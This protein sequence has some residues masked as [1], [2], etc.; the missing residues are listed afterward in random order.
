MQHPDPGPQGLRFAA[1]RWR[2]LVALGDHPLVILER[3]RLWDD[4]GYK[5]LFQIYY[6]TPT[7]YPQ[8]KHLGAVKILQRGAEI[9]EF[10]AEERDGL[11]ERFCSLG[12]DLDY[13]ENVLA[14]GDDTTRAILRG[15]RDM[16]NDPAIFEQFQAEEGVQRSLLRSSAARIALRDGGRLL[17]GQQPPAQIEPLDFEFTCTLPAFSEPHRTRFAFFPQDGQ[18]GRIV[19]LVGRNAAG[20]SALLRALA[21]RLSGLDLETGAVTPELTLL[22]RLIV[23]AY[24]AFDPYT[25]YRRYRS[26]D[27]VAYRYC[28]LRNQDG[29]LD[30]DGAFERMRRRLGTLS[31]GQNRDLLRDVVIRSGILDIEPQLREPFERGDFA[32]FVKEMRSLSAGHQILLFVLAN[33]MA[34]IR[35]GSLVLFD[36]PELHLHP[37]LLTSLMRLLH[38]V[39]ED[40]DSYAILATHSAQVLQEIPARSIR[41][42]ERAGSL[43]SER[44]YPRECFGANLGEITELAFGVDEQ[45]RNYYR[46][47]EGN[48]GTLGREYLMN[49]VFQKPLGL[50][51]RALLGR[52]RGA[53]GGGEETDPE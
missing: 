40:F 23:I 35:P 51:P 52:L 43:P 49:Q 30:I 33:L 10:D 12:Q 45:D 16:A 50:A 46:L 42:L 21:R 17:A 38:Q 47:L 48:A 39:L 25:F 18:L 4:Y 27:G 37:N 9:T 15:L 1:A 29:Q 14:L 13:Y 8:P 36:E 44:P 3:G 24:S 53:G 19:A 26:E 28:G 2:H 31:R 41:I 5:T 20:K 7:E 32:A 6:Y 22:R 11:D 34:T